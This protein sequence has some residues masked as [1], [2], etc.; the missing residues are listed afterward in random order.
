MESFASPEGLLPEQIWDAPDMQERE[1][2]F[3][4]P[5]G[6]AMPLVWAHAEYLKL[7]R[8]MRDGRVFDMPPQTVQRYLVEKTE[9]SWMVWRFN[10]KIRSLLAGR[11]LRIETLAPA[12][13]HWSDDDWN[14][15]HDATTH[16]TG[17]AIHIADLATRSLPEGTQ[18]RFTIYWPDAGKW[19][20]ADFIVSVD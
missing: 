17:L 13:I 15:A 2:F 20:G 4:R 14:T 19:E 12:V 10:H 11:I 7:L 18:V 16:D 1:L 8:S 3:G 5:S 6:S 9:S